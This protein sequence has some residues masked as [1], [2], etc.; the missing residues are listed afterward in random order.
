M[1]R[2]PADYLVLNRPNKIPVWHLVGGL[3]PLDESELT[4]DEP[5][6]GYPVHLKEWITRDGL[7]CLKIKLRGNDSEWDYDRLVKIGGIARQYDVSSLTTDFN[8]TVTDPE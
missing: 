8:C 7:D 3:D 2:Y 4:G 5:E 6:D 1:I